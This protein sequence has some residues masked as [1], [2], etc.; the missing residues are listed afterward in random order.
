MIFFFALFGGKSRNV[1]L[2]TLFLSSTIGAQRYPNLNNPQ[3]CDEEDKRMQE[4]TA[5]GISHYTR[6]GNL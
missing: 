5:T 6:M 4:E 2:Y 1:P 3:G